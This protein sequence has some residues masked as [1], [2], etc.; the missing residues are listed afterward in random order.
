VRAGRRAAG[1]QI[2]FA[3]VAAAVRARREDQRTKD[4]VTRGPVPLC[5]CVSSHLVRMG[6]GVRKTWAGLHISVSFGK[7]CSFSVFN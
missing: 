5:L 2:G 3:Y 4:Q 7:N 1:T 6:L